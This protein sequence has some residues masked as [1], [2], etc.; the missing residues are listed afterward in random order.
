MDLA[1]GTITTLAGTG[2]GGFG[3]DDG[4]ATA[5]QL[6]APYGVAVGSGNLYIADTLNNRVRRV[7][8]Q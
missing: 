8:L 6:Y 7:N 2:A 1:T 5:A 3:G 4:P